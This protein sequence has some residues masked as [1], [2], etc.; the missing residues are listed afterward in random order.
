MSPLGA[1]VLKREGLIAM[2]RAGYEPPVAFFFDAGGTPEVGARYDTL[3]KTLL[4][5]RVLELDRAGTAQ[6]EVRSGDLM[7]HQLVYRP[8]AA[9]V[10]AV[11]DRVSSTSLRMEADMDLYALVLW[12][13]V[14]SLSEGWTSMDLMSPLETLKQF[15]Q[16]RVYVIAFSGLGRSW[17]TDLDALLARGDWYIGAA[18][19]DLGNPLHR[20][21]VALPHT[22]T[23]AS[24]DLFIVGE[25]YDDDSRQE[26]VYN[27][28]EWPF[29][30]GFRS[31]GVG[32]RFDHGETWTGATFVQLPLSAR[33]KLSHRRL[34]AR[35]R[36]THFERVARALQFQ[37]GARHGDALSSGAI[38][39]A[40]GDPIVERGKL[41][42]WCLT[43]DPTRRGG[44]SKARVF[45]SVLGITAADWRFLAAQLASGAKVAEPMDV[46]STP[47]GVKYQTNILVKGRNGQEAPVTA[48]WL[49]EGDAP[50]RLTTAYVA[51]RTSGPAAGDPDAA[52]LILP[53]DEATNWKK[54][55]ELAEA[56]GAQAAE[57]A[58]PT[59]MFISG[60]PPDEEGACGFAWVVIPDARRSFPRWLIKNGFARR[61]H[62]SG[63]HVWGEAGGSQSIERKQA[64][65]AAFARVLRMN[66]VECSVGSRLD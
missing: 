43:E 44:Y 65:A 60:F 54:L 27:Q 29:E 1:R 53:P 17:V 52:S 24:R 8:L 45:R 58:I 59:P 62:P 2:S 63:A 28:G 35:A 66:G 30:L 49:I 41:V 32:D 15:G 25:V 21:A 56:A 48:A 14:D 31:V 11:E 39:F 61:H 23:Y 26:T 37:R 50:P 7:L 6:F 55:Y 40:D 9:E 16:S 38:T 5:R 57:E 46:R 13:F 4:F 34:S 47:W 36:P 19:I 10:D 64:Y 3:P 18:E 12:D 51:R 42:D 33:G 22:L 20:R